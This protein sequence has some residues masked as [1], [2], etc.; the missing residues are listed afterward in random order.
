M[1]GQISNLTL[2]AV[3]ALGVAM[4]VMTARAAADK[5]II[6]TAVAAGQFKTLATALSAAGL[7]DTLKGQGPFTVFAPTDQAFAKL[8]PGTLDSLLKKEN[9]DQL[10]AILTYHVVP[11]ELMAADA[12]KLKEAKTVNGKTVR[13]NL[14]NGKIMVNDATVTGADIPASNGVI[15]IIDSVI[16]PPGS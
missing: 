3:T 13:V 8:P 9:K 7:A 1:N 10:T 15:H 6:D 14:S 12:A 16:L 11:G 2:A 4:G 5:N